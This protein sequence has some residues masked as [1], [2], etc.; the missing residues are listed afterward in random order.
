MRALALDFTIFILCFTGAIVFSHASHVPFDIRQHLSTTTSYGA[1]KALIDKFAGDNISL[2]SGCTPIHLNLVARHGT[3]A[4]TKK[5][6][7]ELDQLAERLRVLTASSAQAP[8]WMREW[9]SPWKGRNVGGELV[10]KG[11]EEMFELGQR[12]HSNF[13]EIFKDNYHPE[14]YPMSAT[15][16]PRS[17]TSAVAFGMGLFAGKGTLGSGLHRSFSVVSDTRLHDLH[18]RFFDTCQTYKET[19]AM[20]TPTVAAVQAKFYAEV[21]A[22][23]VERVKLNITSSDVGALWF[24]CK[25][26]AT[27]LDIVDQACGLFTNEEVEVL[28]WTDDLEFHHLKGYGESINY[29]MG[30]P[31]LKNVWES[32]ETAILASKGAQ[33]PNS[34]ERARFRFAH[35]ETVIPFICLLGLFLDSKDAEKIRSELPLEPPPP[36]PKSRLWKGSVVA[37]FGANTMVVLYKCSTSKGGATEGE[38]DFVVQ[39][40][41]NEKQMTLPACNG[42]HFCPFEVFKENVVLPHLR[43]SYESLCSASKTNPSCSWT[44]QLWK[45]V[46]RFLRLPKHQGSCEDKSEL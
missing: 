6:I 18:L 27:V 15:Q 43:H 23:L 40:L 38:D 25:Q 33:V 4:P 39:V 35:A 8:T 34:A 14:F 37:P 2:P 19:R 22:S 16:V 31:L 36:P 29:R 28:E 41:H 17:A 5:R 44:C 32:M 20:R 9:Q 3:R 24:L 45:V 11:E 1:A 10:I 46:L 30:V 12:V 26:E 7:K 42:A 21:A 13:Q